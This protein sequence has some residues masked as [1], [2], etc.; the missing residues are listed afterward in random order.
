MSREEELYKQQLVSADEYDKIRQQADQARQELSAAT[1]AL[2]VVRD[3]V[4]KSNAS[5]SSTL[6]RS[7]ISGLILDV[8]VKVG[9]TVVLSNTF[10]DGTTIAS[11]ANMNDLI[12]RGNIDETEVG[13]LV[14][15][16]DM[17]I[18]I[19]A[20]QNLHF[21]ASLE[22]ISPKAVGNNGANQF[23][24]KAAVK[25]VKGN[26]IRAGYSANAEIELSRA[27]NVLSVPESAIEFDGDK[28]YVY[29]KTNNGKKAVY[30]RRAV[31]TGL[32]DGVD[33]EIKS[34]LTRKDVVRG[35]EKVT[36]TE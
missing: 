28:T 25:A 10:N 33:I 13:S 30:E 7:T 9:N 20:L 17:K 16:M 31:K 21:Q 1:D 5:A 2:E 11:V 26:K 36:D 14:E 8:P 23:E 22:Y 4:S 32:S 35:P 27:K 12:F 29:V 34:G 15:G 3:G 24:V 18:T 19:G 6:I